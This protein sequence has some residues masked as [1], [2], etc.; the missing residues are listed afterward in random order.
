MP[1]NETDPNASKADVNSLDLMTKFIYNN[2]KVVA[3]KS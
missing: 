1:V 2:K 3:A